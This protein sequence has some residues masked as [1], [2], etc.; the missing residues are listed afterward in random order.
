MAGPSKIQWCTDT[1]NPIVGCS[2]VSPGCTNC[3][4][5][6]MAARLEKMA[7]ST[8]AAHVKVQTHYAGTTQKSKA[9]AVWTGKIARAPEHIL[10]Q[11]LKWKRPRTIFVNSMGDLFH[12]SIPDEWIDPVFAV[13]ALCP[14]HM[15]QVLTKR[16][17]RM[18]SYLSMA[19]AHP[20]GL[21]AMGLTFD[22]HTRDPKSTV[23]SGVILQ[24]DVAHLQKWP[25]PNVWLGVSAERQQEADER[26]PLLLQTPAAIRFVSLE[27]LLGSIDLTAIKYKDAQG[28][29][30]RADQ[31]L[32]WVIV[33]GESGRAARPMHYEWA[34]SIRDQCE[35]AQVPFFFKQVGEWAW[36][37][38]HNANSMI[39][40]N[41]IEPRPN[42]ML[43][44]GPRSGRLLVT[45][46]GK[47]A[48]GRLLDGREWNG[49]P[50]VHHA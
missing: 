14:Q 38:P 13:M 48:A 33:G 23:G 9:G 7:S 45:R 50:E 29:I 41:G 1:W 43:I 5:M 37:G 24:G 3:Y 20:V 44:E 31:D 28:W 32:D 42:Q 22:A 11:P 49:M 16:P 39:G 2:I 15:F 10:L 17:E 40:P 19:R 27:P 46:I 21:E 34:C 8:M 12:E 25:L 30:H 26:I 47:K 6:T 4:A 36:Q 18:R 35:R